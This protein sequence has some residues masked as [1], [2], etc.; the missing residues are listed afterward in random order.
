MDWQKAFQRRVTWPGEGHDDWSGYDG[1]IYI[2]RIMRDL[3][4]YTKRGWFMWSGG[5]LGRD[6]FKKHIIMPHHGREPE[7]WQAAKAVKDWYDRM[8]EANGLPPRK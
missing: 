8:R 6:G 5:A 7:R 4:T 3:T 1:S 2:G